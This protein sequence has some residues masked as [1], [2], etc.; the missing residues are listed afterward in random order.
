MVASPGS[1]RDGSV[2]VCV[3][4]LYSIWVHFLSS[5]K[6]SSI[7]LNGD[8]ND[9]IGLKFLGSIVCNRVLFRF[10]FDSIRMCAIILPGVTS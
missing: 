1:A 4:A 7:D 6:P 3:Y 5:N 8:G 10:W 2:C 9:R